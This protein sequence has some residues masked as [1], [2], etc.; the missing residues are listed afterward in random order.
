MQ[1]MKPTSGYILKSG[2]VFKYKGKIITND[3]LTAEAAE[4]YISQ[5]IDN[6]NQFVELARDYDEYEKV[7]SP[8]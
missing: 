2:A 6:R 7:N 5:D 8:T 3:N 1:K 4:W